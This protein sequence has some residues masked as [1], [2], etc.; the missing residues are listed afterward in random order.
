MSRVVDPLLAARAGG[1]A[2][3]LLITAFFGA[4]WGLVGASALPDGP[5]LP[6]TLVV[7]AVTAI[8][9]LAAARLFRLSRRS[10][11]PPPGGAG[12]NPFKART[13]RLAVL[14]E[15][16]A[17]PLAAL[18]LNRAGHPD[19]V[20]S[21]VAAI[22]GLHFFG[23]VPAFGSWGFAAV[24]GAMVVVGV[25]SLLLPAAAAGGGASPRSALVG[26]GCA[27]ALW[28]GVVPPLVSTLRR[29]GRDPT[30]HK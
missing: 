13:Y 20:V 24:G 18:V 17:I 9:L 28:G 11:N 29:A 16:V 3:V 7:V 1:L 4:W 22:V 10:P 12:S 15:V 2:V 25:L 30:E 27:L 26:T 23:L 5:S 21:V 8:L 14:F 6:A 19:A